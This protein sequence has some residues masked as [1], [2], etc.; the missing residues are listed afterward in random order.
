M[1]LILLLLLDLDVLILQLLLPLFLTEVF[2]EVR[3]IHTV[4]HSRLML[5]PESLFVVLVHTYGLIVIHQSLQLLS[6][7]LSL[8]TGLFVLCDV[9]LDKGVYFFAF[10]RVTFLLLVM[11]HCTEVV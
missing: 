7:A 11:F 10:L 9:K 5:F 2:L 4:L 1:R 3:L 8:E 6:P